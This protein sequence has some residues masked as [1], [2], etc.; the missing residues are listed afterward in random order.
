MQAKVWLKLCYT[1]TQRFSKMYDS[2]YFTFNTFSSN[3]SWQT[4][5]HLIKGSLF[6]VW[7]KWSRQHSCRRHLLLSTSAHRSSRGRERGVGGA[8]KREGERENEKRIDSKWV[9]EGDLKEKLTHLQT[10]TYPGLTFLTHSNQGPFLV[11]LWNGHR[12]DFTYPRSPFSSM[13]GNRGKEKVPGI[14]KVTRRTPLFQCS[15]SPAPE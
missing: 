11:K 6:K 8:S 4:Q 10:H 13:L 5:F 14:P 9:G 12:K 7:V 1:K 2:E 3:Q 15:L